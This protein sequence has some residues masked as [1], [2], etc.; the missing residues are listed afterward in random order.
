MFSD[1][2]NETGIG[3][4]IHITINSLDGEIY[5]FDY[6]NDLIPKKIG[7]VK[8]DGSLAKILVKDEIGTVGSISF[9]QKSRRVYWSDVS[10][11]KIE[12]ISIDSLSDRSVVV[13]DAEAPY[14]F[15]LWDLESDTTLYYADHVQEQL[16]ALSLK[17][18]D[19]RV[20][21]SNVANINQLKIYRPQISDTQRSSPCL[22]NNGGCHQ[23]C[24][25]SGAG[26]QCRCGNGLEL[27]DDGS[28]RPYQRFIL[29]SSPMFMRAL[30][31]DSNFG[32]EAIPIIPGYQIG[33]V[34]FILK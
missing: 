27:L 15:A 32:D 6:G 16:I 19:K 11:K 33:K 24:V 22:I 4:I 1:T 14:A 3:R 18:G 9:H 25:S 8:M 34:F 2:A 31:L 28:C 26:R 7:S 20:M 5:W 29:Y 21:K 10:R 13:S 12:S 30:P 23:I 17:T